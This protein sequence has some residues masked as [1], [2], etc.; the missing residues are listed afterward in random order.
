MERDL[1]RI[2]T[3]NG[4]EGT[5]SKGPPEF[6]RKIPTQR[7]QC[8]ATKYTL[9]QITL[10]CK[11]QL[12][13]VAAICGFRRVGIRGCQSLGFS[14]VQ[15]S[16]RGGS[17]D[18]RLAGK[19]VIHRAVGGRLVSEHA[20]HADDLPAMHDGMVEHMPQDFPARKAPLNVARKLQI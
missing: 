19:V 10:Y 15:R 14:L 12:P 20:N 13:K 7:D 6:P 3:P 1:F 16:R 2:W 8:V 5:W 9:A 17:N 11:V 4:E 18:S